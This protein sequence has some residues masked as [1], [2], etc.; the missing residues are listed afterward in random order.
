MK[1]VLRLLCFAAALPA[2]LFNVPAAARDASAVIL[3]GNELPAF[4]GYQL[5]GIVA[6]NYSGGVWTDVPLQID[7]RAVKNGHDIYFEDGVCT[8]SISECNRIDIDLLVYTDANTFAGADDDPTFD[9]DDELVLLCS[10]AADKAPAGTYPAAVPNGSERVEIRIDDPVNSLTQYLY[11]FEKPGGYSPPVFTPDVVYNFVL[12]NP[13][14]Y[15]SQFG[16]NPENSTVVTGAYSQHFADRWIHDDINIL[17]GTGVDILDRHKQLFPTYACSHTDEGYSYGEGVFTANISGPIRAIRAYV[18]SLSGPLVER[19]HVFYADHEQIVTKLRVHA[20]AGNMDVYD[21]NANAIGMTYYNN[22]N[23]GGLTV[24]G[25]PEAAA[26]GELTFELISGPQGSMYMVHQLET[27]VTLG[28]VTSRYVDAADNS[29]ADACTGDNSA[30]GYSG[31]ELVNIPDTDPFT[32]P[33][34]FLRMYRS[35]LYDGP[36]KTPADLNYFLQYQ[37][38]PLVISTDGGSVCLTP[39]GL[40]TDQ[41]DKT[42]ARCNWNAVTGAVSYTLQWRAV[43]AGNWNTVGSLNAT[44]QGLTGLDPDTEY[45]WQIKTACSGDESLFSA[46]QTFTT[47]LCNAAPVPAGLAATAQSASTALLSWDNMDVESYDVELYQKRNN[48]TRVLETTYSAVT[49]NQQL[50][51]GLSDKKTYSF[52]VRSNCNAQSSAYSAYH[53]FSTAG[54]RSGADAPT[55]DESATI[56]SLGPNPTDGALQLTVAAAEGGEWSVEISDLRGRVVTRR[57]WRSIVGAHTV[58][59]DVTHLDAAVYFVTLRDSAGRTLGSAKLFKF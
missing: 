30:Y 24:D 46:S 8:L 39:G 33:G 37:Q 58:E 5:D 14:P 52:R 44:N 20:I 35:V 10:D 26:T 48:G 34:N 56:F 2:L 3:T 32:S 36:N 16:F 40:F 31:P 51:S 57:E 1:I 42:T 47:L 19:N 50:A 11:L 13:P 49:D 4:L 59:L 29:G 53:D 28:G 23:P 21:Y 15:N 6:F 9:A 45:E 25:V 22:L 27:N 7:E 12:L 38:Q 41:I 55:A 18:G 54:A 17:A 43:G